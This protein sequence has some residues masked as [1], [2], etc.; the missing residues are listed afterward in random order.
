MARIDPQSFIYA[1]GQNIL[2]FRIQK[3]LSQDDLAGRTKIDRAV[4]S[5]Y[6]NG[7]QVMRID[8]LDQLAK[9]LEVS[10]CDFVDTCPAEPDA[11]FTKISQQLKELPPN[12]QQMIRQTIANTASNLINYV[13]THN[14]H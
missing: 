11:L 6:E 14:Q 5:K 3:G 1:V 13:K 2:K 7:T 9:A 12:D 4:I 8:R 10:P